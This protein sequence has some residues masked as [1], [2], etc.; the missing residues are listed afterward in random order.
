MLQPNRKTH[1]TTL[2]DRAI[3]VCWF[4][5]TRARAS[6]FLALGDCCGGRVEIRALLCP[7]CGYVIP[8][9]NAA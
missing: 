2:I 1:A 5:G 8:Q 7:N 3:A 9:R 4:C 6:A